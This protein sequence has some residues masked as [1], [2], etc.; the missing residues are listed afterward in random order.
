MEF[1]AGCVDSHCD[2][3]IGTLIGHIEDD[4]ALS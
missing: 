4:K 3:F 2:D 1:R